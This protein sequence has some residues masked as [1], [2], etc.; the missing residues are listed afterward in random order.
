MVERGSIVSSP[1]V[2]RSRRSLFV[3]ASLI[4]LAA[5]STPKHLRA[6]A[7]ASL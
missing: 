3:I 7:I 4:S 2:G 6:A 5:A 1:F